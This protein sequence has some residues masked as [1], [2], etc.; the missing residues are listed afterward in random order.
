[1]RARRPVTA[2]PLRLAGAVA[3]ALLLESCFIEEFPSLLGLYECTMTVRN[4]EGAEVLVHSRQHPDFFRLDDAG[5][6]ESLRDFFACAPAESVSEPAS[7]PFAECNGCAMTDRGEVEADWDRWVAVRIEQLDELEE[8]DSEFT[9]LRGPWCQVPETRSCSIFSGWFPEEEAWRG[10][11]DEPA[12]EDPILD[13][14]TLPLCPPLAGPVEIRCGDDGVECTV[15]DFGELPVGG[16]AARTVTLTNTGVAGEADVTVRFDGT[17]FTL[18]QQADF[19]VVDNGCLPGTPEEIEAG[20]KTLVSALVDPEAASC[21]FTVEFR[22]SNPRQH[23]GG[24]DFQTSASPQNRIRLL[25]NGVAGALSIDAPDPFCV[26]IASPCSQPVAIGLDNAGPGGVRIDDARIEGG[27]TG[28]E[29]NPID[30]PIALAP[31][32]S[33]TVQVRWC[34]GGGEVGLLVIDSNAATPTLDI[35]LNAEASCTAP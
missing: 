16:T 21:E 35:G 10:F 34:E 28:F 11:P 13:V 29:I 22:P 27:N 3:A 5:E 18:G 15:I 9:L 20:G 8:G 2:S 24:L 30:L 32:E 25:G 23:N 31:G 14:E 26:E 4:A 1:M 17:V 19:R 6:P 12:C 33:S 7:L